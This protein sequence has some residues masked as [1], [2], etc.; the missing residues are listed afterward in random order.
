MNCGTVFVATKTRQR[1]ACDVT[2]E[3]SSSA[4][5]FLSLI[6]S[7]S[8]LLLPPLVHARA[9]A[10]ALIAYAYRSTVLAREYARYPPTLLSSV[11]CCAVSSTL[12]HLN[13]LSRGPRNRERSRATRASSGRSV[14]KRE[15]YVTQVTQ[16]GS[17]SLT[18][19]SGLARCK[20]KIAIGQIL[21]I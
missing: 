7:F 18:G 20:W 9:R 8:G 17:L 2:C 4:R 13:D 11:V 6:R 19:K 12:H 21:K 5:A 14:V 15:I 3:E 16:K 1:E 10:R